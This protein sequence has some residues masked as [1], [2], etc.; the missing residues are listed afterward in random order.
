M[1]LEDYE[2]ICKDCQAPFIFKAGEQLFYRDKGLTPP[3]RCLDCRAQRK[4]FFENRGKALC[5]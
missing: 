5:Q 3:H 2:I 1:E 4:A